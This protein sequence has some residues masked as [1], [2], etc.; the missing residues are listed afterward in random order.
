MGSD[1][2]DDLVIERCVDVRELA[3]PSGGGTGTVS[4]NNHAFQDLRKC[5]WED[6]RDA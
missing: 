3:W 5:S 4:V 1:A 2:L 6:T